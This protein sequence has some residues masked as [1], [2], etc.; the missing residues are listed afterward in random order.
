MNG[1]N[2]ASRYASI[3]VKARGS[4]LTMLILTIINVILIYTDAS[5]SFPFSASFP[6]IAVVVGNQLAFQSGNNAWI[7]FAAALTIISIVP[8]F[9][10]WYLS[11]SPNISMLVA[12]IFFCVD[13]IF[14]IFLAFLAF[15][16]YLIMDFAFHGWVIY[17]L[18][19]GVSAAFKFKKLP[20]EQLAE[21]FNDINKNQR[22]VFDPKLYSEEA[23]ALRDDVSGK[24]RQIIS[25][26][27]G[28]DTVIV[29]RRYGVT[30]LIINQKVYAEYKGLLEVSYYIVAN[31]GGTV[32]R[33]EFV[34]NG[35]SGI[36]RLYADE[37]CIGEK[38]RIR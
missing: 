23:S 30:E 25:A 4:L 38:K 15:D 26:V 28:A 18:A 19:I 37:K 11:K 14:L 31:V 20:P 21:A 7:Y 35:F 17:S 1:K 13:T 2:S 33:T 36:Q 3:Y 6:Q 27:N 24:G 22:P 34:S 5:I 8:Y 12:L 29:K 10:C 32:Y 9:I 16:T